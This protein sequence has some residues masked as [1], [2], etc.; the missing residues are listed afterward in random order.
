MI[1]LKSIVEYNLNDESIQ[2]I[3]Q[4]FQDN[5]SIIIKSIGSI[6]HNPWKINLPTYQK[7]IKAKDKDLGP[8]FIQPDLNSN[9]SVRKPSAKLNRI[10]NHSNALTSESTRTDK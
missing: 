7:Q 8:W 3:A 4:E 9:K 10:L 1:L 6:R 2:S 5:D